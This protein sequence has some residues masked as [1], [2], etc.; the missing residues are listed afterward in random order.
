MRKWKSSSTKSSTKGGRRAGPP[1]LFREREGLRGKMSADRAGV[2][3][4]RGQ[5]TSSYDPAERVPPQKTGSSSLASSSAA[6]GSFLTPEFTFS[7]ALPQGRVEGKV[8]EAKTGWFADVNAPLVSP[9]S[10]GVA[11]TPLDWAEVGVQRGFGE[12]RSASRSEGGW[13]RASASAPP[14]DW[15]VV[16]R[17]SSEVAPRVV[18]APEAST[19]MQSIRVREWRKMLTLGEK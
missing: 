2:E 4:G 17:R 19:I 14:S 9:A 11:S 1:S 3:A 15:E 18:S 7:D 12:V 8:I 10:S 6:G 13:S 5:Q 16:P